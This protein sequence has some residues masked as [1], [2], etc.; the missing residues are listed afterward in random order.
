MNKDSLIYKKE[1]WVKIKEEMETD[2]TITY[3]SIRIPYGIALQKLRNK[4]LGKNQSL[5]NLFSHDIYIENRV[6]FKLLKDNYTEKDEL[7]IKNTE[8]KFIDWCINNIEN[9]KKWIN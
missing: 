1:T 5:S 7:L 4:F 8:R 2:L 3:G 9:I 6:L